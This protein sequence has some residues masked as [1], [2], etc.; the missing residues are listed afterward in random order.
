MNFKVF[1]DLAIYHH[2][3]GISNFGKKGFGVAAPSR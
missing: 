1:L 3:P 2:V